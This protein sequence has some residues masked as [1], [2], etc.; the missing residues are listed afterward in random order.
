MCH[1]RGLDGELGDVEGRV[2]QDIVCAFVSAECHLS[3]DDVCEDVADAFF[4][5][6]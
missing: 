1:S 6:Q 4:G 5:R 3:D 2:G